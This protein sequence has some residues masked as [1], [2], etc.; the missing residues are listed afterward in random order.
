MEILLSTSMGLGSAPTFQFFISAC[1]L[2]GVERAPFSP[3]PSARLREA[4]LPPDRYASDAE[5]GTIPGPGSSPFSA[6]PAWPPA[7]LRLRFRHRHRVPCLVLA[8]TSTGAGDPGEMPR[9]ARLAFSSELCP[10]PSLLTGF[11]VC[12][13]SDVEMPSMHRT[14]GTP[15]F[16]PMGSMPLEPSS[17]LLFPLGSQ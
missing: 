11:G 4:F 12:L 7:G 5:Q 3:Q 1:N 8:P 15:V 14:W 10:K 9:A 17:W 13:G 16:F 2:S 6:V